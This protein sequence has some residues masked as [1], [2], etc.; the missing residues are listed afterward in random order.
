[1]K[2][3]ATCRL[4][5]VVVVVVLVLI[6]WSIPVNS[7]ICLPCYDPTTGDYVGPTCPT[8]PSVQCEPSYRHCSC[9]MECAGKVGDVCHQMTPP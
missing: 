6:E 5:A 8:L 9:C 2:L 7:M 3:D 4:L 1:M